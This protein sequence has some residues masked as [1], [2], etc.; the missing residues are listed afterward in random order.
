MKVKRNS[1]KR[2]IR[3]K[4]YSTQCNIE[5]SYSPYINIGKCK[6]C[7]DLQMTDLSNLPKTSNNK[8]KWKDSVGFSVSYIV[9]DEV[10]EIHIL[11]YK[12]DKK[13]EYSKI[14]IQ[15]KNN[16][17][18]VSPGILLRP[19]IGVIAGKT[20]SDFI[21]NIGEIINIGCNTFKVID[22]K[23]DK[24]KKYYLE[25][26]ICQNK[27]WKTEN[28]ILNCKK[29]NKLC[30]V[31][32]NFTLKE[33]FNDIPTIANWMIPYFENGYDEAKRYT[34]FSNKEIVPICPYCNKKADRSYKISILYRDKG[35]KCECKNIGSYGENLVG[36]VLRQNGIKFRRDKEFVWSKKKRYDYILDDWK[37]IIEV[38][39]EY[40]HG[41]Y[42]PWKT[43]EQSEKEFEIDELKNNLALEN[44]YT[45][46]RLTYL[47]DYQNEFI[48]EIKSML[49][50][51]FWEKT[52]WTKAIENTQKTVKKEICKLYENSNKNRNDLL[53]IAKQYGYC[54]NTIRN[55][56]KLGNKLGWCHY[57][58]E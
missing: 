11:D 31:C 48:D 58:K 34:P 2:L 49:P 19:N 50:K 35:F 41:F 32:S 56:L 29:D 33:G 44:D 37:L 21:Y 17:K 26:L 3:Y 13:T 5:V 52:D 45:I 54:E 4:M 55:Y 18:W 39:G 10:G 14:L 15:C 1:L 8:I 47:S 36:E 28:A 46:L 9:G 25:C 23:Q 24:R 30:S 22:R 43:Y 38:D 7:D 51:Q 27:S 16:K 20:R 57:P 6:G 12:Y 40:G 53:Q 42:Q